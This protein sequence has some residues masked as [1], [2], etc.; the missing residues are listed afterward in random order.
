MSGIIR[1]R[2]GLDPPGIVEPLAPPSTSE[3]TLAAANPG[4]YP[5]AADRCPQSAEIAGT[6]RYTGPQPAFAGL[7]PSSRAGRAVVYGVWDSLRAFCRGPELEGVSGIWKR[8]RLARGSR[9][10][11]PR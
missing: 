9:G 7:H 11:C 6:A 1:P 8:A 2:P 3:G 10:H 4:R 5:G